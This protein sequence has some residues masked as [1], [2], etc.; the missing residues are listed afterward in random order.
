[1]RTY[2]GQISIYVSQLLE[3]YTVKRLEAQ[4]KDEALEKFERY[5]SKLNEQETDITIEY[6]F[7]RLDG[8]NQL[9]I[10]P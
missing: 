1:M 10:I 9:G 5:I 4:N 7:K 8:V 2:I 3:G 6:I